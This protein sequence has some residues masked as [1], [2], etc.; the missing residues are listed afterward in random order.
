MTLPRWV[1]R[2]GAT[3]AGLLIALAVW[4]AA[5]ALLTEPGG[6]WTA[7]RAVHVEGVPVRVAIRKNE[8]DGQG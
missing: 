5:I 1:A 8:G 3:I 6:D 7:E 4:W 2:A